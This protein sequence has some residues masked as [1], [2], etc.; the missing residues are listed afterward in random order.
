MAFCPEHAKRDQNQKFT[1]Q[2][3]APPLFYPCYLHGSW[4]K[5][6]KGIFFCRVCDFLQFHLIHFLGPF[7]DIP[8]ILHDA[9]RQLRVCP[10]Y[11]NHDALHFLRIS[12]LLR[13]FSARANVCS[14]FLTFLVPGLLL[15]VL[16]LWWRI[17]DS[18]YVFNRGEYDSSWPSTPYISRK[19]TGTSKSNSWIQTRCR[20]FRHG[21]RR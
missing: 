4:K 9:F 13:Y 18:Y 20:S 8:W 21:F 17:L 11:V 3:C 5:I 14:N 10:E 19:T 15:N 12:W 6:V 16:T 2:W 1:T 7:L